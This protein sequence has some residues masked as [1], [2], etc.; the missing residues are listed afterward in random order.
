[1]SLYQ[2][3]INDFQSVVANAKRD[4]NEIDLIAVSKKK[5]SEDIKPVIQAG[6]LSYG[7]NQI[8]EVEQKWQSLKSEFSKVKLHFIGSIQ[9]R[10]VSSIYNNCD[11]IHSLDRIKIVKLFSELEKSQSV[12][13]EYFIQINTGNESQKSG[14]MVS[15][16]DQFIAECINNYNL[17]IQGLMCIPPLDANPEDHFLQLSSIAR[18]FNLPSLS[19]GMSNDYEI[20]LKCGAT[21]IRIGTKIFGTRN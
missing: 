21:H 12:S 20:A 11:V 19:M 5:S 7:E 17:N 6:H 9:S 15:E 8:Q 13:K 2:T 1:M 18:N 3:F 16:A 10:K 4:I 14:V